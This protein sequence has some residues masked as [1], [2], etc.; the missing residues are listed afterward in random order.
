MSPIKLNHLPQAP[1]RFSM[2]YGPQ[3]VQSPEDAGNITLSASPEGLGSF[4]IGIKTICRDTMSGRK[5]SSFAERHF[6]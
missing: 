2:N 1:R 6:A 4:S 5:A 3:I